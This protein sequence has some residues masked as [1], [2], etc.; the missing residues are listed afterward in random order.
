MR[1]FLSQDNFG[2][3]PSS[4][5]WLFSPES[6]FNL[7]KTRE[8]KH[9]NHQCTIHLLALLSLYV[10]SA[11]YFNIISEEPDEVPLDSKV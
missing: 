8:S 5:S 11:L 10:S 9:A 6:T 1:C 7:L 3:D 2:M 4:V